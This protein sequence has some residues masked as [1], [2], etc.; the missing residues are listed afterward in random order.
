MFAQ[1]PFIFEI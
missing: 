1:L